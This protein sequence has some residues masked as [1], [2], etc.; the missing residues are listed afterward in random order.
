LGFYGKSAGDHALPAMGI[1]RSGNE[2]GY[3]TH[4]VERR[5]VFIAD[6]WD[7]MPEPN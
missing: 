7:I 1:V 5:Q 3:A 4:P 2:D 6:H